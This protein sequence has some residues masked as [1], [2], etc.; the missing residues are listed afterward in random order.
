VQV[1]AVYGHAVNNNPDLGDK[2]A[3]LQGW[4]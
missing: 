2:H 3:R 1:H 4:R